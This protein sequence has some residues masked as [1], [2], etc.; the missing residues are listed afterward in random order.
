MA[1]VLDLELAEEPIPAVVK[2]VVAADPLEAAVDPLAV[3][4]D[5]PAEELDLLAEE[6]DLQVE[7]L[8]EHHQQHQVAAQVAAEPP[9]LCTHPHL[10]ASHQAAER[11]AAAHQALAQLKVLLCRQPVYQLR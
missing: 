4:A 5:P 7:E 6:L 8:A 2:V 1:A 11:A 9:H 3:V 10:R